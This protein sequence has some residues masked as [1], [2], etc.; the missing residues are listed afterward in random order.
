MGLHMNR[1]SL[2]NL[3]VKIPLNQVDVVSNIYH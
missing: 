3:R 2:V 1:N